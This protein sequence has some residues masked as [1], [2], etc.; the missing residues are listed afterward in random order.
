MEGRAAARNRHHD[1][2]LLGDTSRAALEDLVAGCLRKP[3]VTALRRGRRRLL[4]QSRQA[5]QVG[6]ASSDLPPDPTIDAVPDCT[7][8]L[9]VPPRLC[10]ACNKAMLTCLQILERPPPFLRSFRAHA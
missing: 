3:W 1:Q 6:A 2:G 8:L 5:L 7:G 4:A 10:P 9:P